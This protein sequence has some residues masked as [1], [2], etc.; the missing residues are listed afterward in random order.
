MVWHHQ[1]FNNVDN[2]LNLMFVDAYIIA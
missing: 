1:Y 2:I